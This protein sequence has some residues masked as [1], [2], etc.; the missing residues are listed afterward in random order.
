MASENV[1][2]PVQWPRPMNTSAPMP[3]ASSPGTSTSSIVGPPSPPASISRNAPTMGEPSSVLTDA[4]LPV[5]ASTDCTCS[6]LAA[7]TR[8]TAQAPSPPPS[9]ISG[10]SG[11]RTAPK[12]SVAR[13]ARTTPGISLAAGWLP[14]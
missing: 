4:K 11:P 8:L 10:A 7:R 13:A 2:S 14:V 6:A 1:P 5:A 9:A 12:P 3:D